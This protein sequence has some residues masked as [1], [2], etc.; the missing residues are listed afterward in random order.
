MKWMQHFH[1]ILCPQK[2]MQLQ[3]ISI[4]SVPNNNFVWWFHH[5]YDWTFTHISVKSF[6]WTLFTSGELWKGERTKEES[7]TFASSL[8]VLDVATTDSRGWKVCWFLE[9]KAT[10]IPVGVLLMMKF[11]YT[12]HAWYPPFCTRNSQLSVVLVLCSQTFSWGQSTRLSSRATM[13]CGY[14]EAT[15]C[16]TRLLYIWKTNHLVNVS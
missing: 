9:L 5:W 10:E 3:S 4:R 15:A 6:M 13:V 16:G 8:K 7:T 12:T 14:I 11:R 2:L 1:Y